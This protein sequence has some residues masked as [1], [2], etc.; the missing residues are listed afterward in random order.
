MSETVMKDGFYLK[1]KDDEGTKGGREEISNGGYTA[2]RHLA[3][4]EGEESE[5]TGQDQPPKQGNMK[6][7]HKILAALL[8]VL[9][10][11]G[12]WWWHELRVT[13]STADA[14]VTADIS[15]ISAKV[16]GRLVNLYVSEGDT[17]TAGQELA[18]LDNDQL[19]AAESQAEAALELAT[20]S[21]DKLPDT[22]K[23]AQAN[24]DK[25][26]QGLATAQDME[27]MAEIALGD[28]KRNLEETQA[29]YS[30]Q[31][32]SKDALDDANSR[33]GTA[34]ATLDA[35]RANALIGPG[36]LTGRPSP[37]GCTQQYRGGLQPGCH[38]TGPGGI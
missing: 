32:A 5:E 17:V 2:G 15:D 29:L 18:S 21:Y 28:A 22:I 12:L 38:E 26:E 7:L 3:K 31:A 9:L 8:F 20:A 11:G 34:Q 33:Y 24:V 27:K 30:S 13:Y 14:Q 6:Q 35:G 36:N 16:G 10:V 19:A 1:G 4:L 23:S 37:T 25:A